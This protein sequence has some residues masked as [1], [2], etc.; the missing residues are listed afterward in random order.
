MSDKISIVDLARAKEQNRKFAA[1]SCYDYTTAKLVSQT[2]IEMIIVGDSAAQLML[3]FDSTL[4]VTMDFMVTI[5]AAV[6][7]GAPD[8]CLVA[9]MP[10]S[11]YQ[12]CGADAVENAQ[13]FITETNAQIVKIE[14][15]EEQVAIVKSVSD[16]GIPTM[17]HIGIRPQ[18]GKLK[19]QAS[20]VE[21]AVELINLADKV[22]EAGGSALL[23]EGT[24]REVAKIITEKVTVPVIGCGSGPDC[25]GQVLVL[26]DVLGL[27]SGPMPK[28]SKHFAEIGSAITETVE[29]Y[30]KQISNGKFPDDEH[31][32]HMKSGEFE[33]LQELLK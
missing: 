27:T 30:A 10:F 19:A 24:T 9:D 11:A 16:A 23:L 15:T 6:R 28:F 17:P 26:T 20:T 32:Y 1:V 7:R 29:N 13:R 18:T 33:K 2:P 21:S 8:L 3:G 14:V 25:D 31:C 22:V 12:I 4:P 5:T